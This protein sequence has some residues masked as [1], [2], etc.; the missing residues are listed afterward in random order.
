MGFADSIAGKIASAKASNG[1]NF[2]KDGRYKLEIKALKL[3]K[4]YAGLTFI[5]ELGVVESAPVRDDVIPNAV[6]TTASYIQQLDKREQ[7]AYP[8]TKA[9]LLA[10]ADEDE[11]AIS[12][13]EFTAFINDA[14]GAKQALKGVLIS[15]ETFRKFTKDGKTEMT[16]P[17]FT[18]IKQTDAEVAGR[19]KALE[20]AAA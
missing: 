18:A 8:N 2:L 16:L 3:E 4:L 7:T 5:A 15:C 17:R 10:A 12:A 6:G 19:R 13:E 14:T 20:G 1:G 9:F 11:S